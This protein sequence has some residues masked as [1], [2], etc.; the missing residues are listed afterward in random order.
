MLAP[1]IDHT[2]LAPD[3]TAKDIDKLCDEAV[4]YGFASV[5][6]Q[7][8]RVAQAAAAL[9]GTA[10]KVCTVVG[11]PHGANG[12]SAKAHEAAEAIAAGATEIDMV[13]NLG[14]VKDGAWDIVAKE[15][16]AVRAAC[17]DAILKVILETAILT[18]EEIRKA[19]RLCVEVGVH[20]VKTSTGF[21]GGGATVHAVRLLR[22]HVPASMGVK[23]SGGIRDYA[24]AKAMIEAGADRLGCS[25][26]VAICDE[27][28]AQ[29]K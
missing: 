1:L 4:R 5:C 8:Y 6:V 23:A 21:T 27:E 29:T 15:I 22:E 9:A 14:A 19:C 12:A 2:L 10:V 11:F 3:A 28:A 20:F 18:D 26:G 16:R 25:A 7:P 24:T 13:Q 17:G